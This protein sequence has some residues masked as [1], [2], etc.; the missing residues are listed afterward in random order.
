MRRGMSRVVPIIVLVVGLVACGSG[1]E[2]ADGPDVQVVATT[3]ILADVV[4]NIVGDAAEVTAILPP[5]ADPHDYQASSADA[6]LIAGADLVVAN[7]L[8]LEEGLS[9]VLA[10]ARTDG[11]R[12]LEVAP[13]VDPIEFDGGGHAEH[14]GE[15]DH[16]DDED[17]ADE[18]H[19]E[20]DGHEHSLDPHF[21]FDPLRVADAAAAIASA[22]AEIE[23]TVDWSAGA[24]GYA[25][26]L[27]EADTQIEALLT[28]VPDERRVLITNHDSLG[29][30][31]DRYGYEVVGTVVPGGSTLAEPSSADLAEL[32][33]AI[34]EEDVRAIFVDNS[35]P[36]TL[37]E[38]VATEVGDD[39]A[40]VEL[41]TGTLGTDDDTDS[42]IE[43]LIED[44]LRISEA[45]GAE[46]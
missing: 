26:A 12:V 41:F 1:E 43:V 46:G 8:G 16:E 6:A 45:L 3:T 44:A 18:D 27:G 38:A 4:S 28:S 19:E 15:G 9:D 25:E 23:P 22:L 14:E 10:S 32:V 24:E 7:G 21:W 40:V 34:L 5:G 2:G 42:L 31:A 30:L 39:I 33:A 11:V 13:L 35:A 29:Y 36:S 20:E 17:H 37:A